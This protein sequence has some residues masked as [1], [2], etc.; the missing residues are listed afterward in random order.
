MVKALGNYFSGTE[1]GLIGLNDF[2]KHGS[3]EGNSVY[4]IQASLF[5][6]SHVFNKAS[7]QNEK[8]PQICCCFL[9]VND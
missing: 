5:R 6:S 2:T 3:L 8:A 9:E 4:L 7:N 1:R